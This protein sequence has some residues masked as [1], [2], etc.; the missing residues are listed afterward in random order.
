MD[1]KLNK[2]EEIILKTMIL[3]EIQILEQ[4]EIL[5]KEDKKYINDLKR[6]FNKIGK[7]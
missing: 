7:D 3:N 4:R 1:R 5:Y 2:N 6:I